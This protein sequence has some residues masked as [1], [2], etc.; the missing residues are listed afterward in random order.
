MG[1]L[2]KMS[3]SLGSG[4]GLYIKKISSHGEL[5]YLVEGVLKKQGEKLYD[6]KLRTGLNPPQMN[7]DK[8]AQEIGELLQVTGGE[9]EQQRCDSGSVSAEQVNVKWRPLRGGAGP[10][11]LIQLL[12]PALDC[13]S[14]VLSR[15]PLQEEEGLLEHAQQVLLKIHRHAVL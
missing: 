1:G 15:H 5:H 3:T 13:V 4:N 9:T 14:V 6:W 7:T 12:Q 2:I 8:Q 10:V 11:L